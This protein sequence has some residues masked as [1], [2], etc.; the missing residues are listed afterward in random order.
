MTRQTH[1]AKTARPP[2]PTLAATLT[3]TLALTQSQMAETEVIGTE[4]RSSSCAMPGSILVAVTAQ[5]SDNRKVRPHI[6]EIIITHRTKTQLEVAFG[7]TIESLQI[8]AGVGAASGR[9]GATASAANDAD[10]YFVNYIYIYMLK[11]QRGCP[12]KDGS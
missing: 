3:A 6:S 11:C 1:G 8:F 2:T 4:A 9:G 7:L 10:A 12:D 5:P